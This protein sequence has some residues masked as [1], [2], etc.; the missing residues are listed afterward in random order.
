MIWIAPSYASGA[1]GI[2]RGIN[3]YSDKFDDEDDKSYNY[4]N[5]SF[6]FDLKYNNKPL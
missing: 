2:V 6:K 3:S 4:G 5:L 1:K